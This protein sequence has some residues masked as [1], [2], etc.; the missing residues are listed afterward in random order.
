MLQALDLAFYFHT[1]TS[2]G[3]GV[4]DCCGVLLCGL[5]ED[6]EFREYIFADS[7]SGAVYIEFHWDCPGVCSIWVLLGYVEGL[8]F[9]VL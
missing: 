6:T 1:Y 5:C 8:E 4:S 2:V 3:D 9:V 7:F